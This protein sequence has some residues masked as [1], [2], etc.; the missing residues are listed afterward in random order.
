[1]I[2]YFKNIVINFLKMIKRRSFK[3]GAIVGKN[4]SLLLSA[5]VNNCTKDKSRIK[6]G[7][8]CEIGAKIHIEGNGSIS[9][10]D[11]TT[12]RGNTAV[13]S[14]N[15]IRIGNYVGISN[16]CTLRDHNSHP[17][18]PS[19]RR[20][21][22]NSGFYGPLW[23]NIHAESAPITIHD[24]VWI[25]EKSIIL[26][27]VTIGEGSI[28]ATGAVVTKDVPPYSIVAGNPAKIVKSLT[29]E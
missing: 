5:K 4:F 29:T 10:G 20:E 7:N 23:S 21:M 2:L 18:S 6:I 8:N 3:K 11:Y 26:K 22:F 25:G 9:I 19:K 14:V 1:M 24:N 13:S 17:T 27:G 16:N 15:Q 12:I 28:V